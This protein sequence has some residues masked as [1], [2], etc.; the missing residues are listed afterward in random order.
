MIYLLII[1]EGIDRVG[2]TTTCN[3]IKETF[4][5]E[6]FKENNKNKINEESIMFSNYGSMQSIINCY[7]SFG[8]NVI[9]DR[10]H[11][12]EFIYGT[13]QRNYDKELSKRIFEDID[14]N[15]SEIEDAIMIYI[16]PTDIEKSS[17]MH[18][19]SLH[20]H[21]KLFDSLFEKSKIKKII[22][23]FN[24]LENAL[25]YIDFELYRNS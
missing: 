5:F 16:K 24:T 2:K 10:F 13:L 7:K 15:I 18:G 3:K 12:S 23:N 19:K 9:L 6:I 20:E 22:V 17:Q 21:D 25:N 11:L 1:V 14:R 4:G 8:K